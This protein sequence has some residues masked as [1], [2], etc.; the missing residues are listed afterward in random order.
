M[1]PNV[2]GHL[3]CGVWPQGTLFFYPHLICQTLGF[4]P[5]PDST[6]TAPQIQFLFW[7]RPY[8]N[9]A[10][11]TFISDMLYLAVSIF[12]SA[13][14]LVRTSYLCT[15][16]LI[17]DRIQS[18]A[19]C[20]PVALRRASCCSLHSSRRLLAALTVFLKDSQWNWG[21][22]PKREIV[23]RGLWTLTCYFISRMK[24]GH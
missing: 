3:Q 1:S 9:R 24:Q 18:G 20:L 23:Q 19:V 15:C 2:L 5:L 21:K 11:S 10:L 8:S 7:H 6:G 22:T 14:S 13:F 4:V 12:P 16:F 17:S